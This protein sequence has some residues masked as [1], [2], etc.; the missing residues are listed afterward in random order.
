MI[1]NEHVNN[2][3]NA[4]AQ[5]ERELEKLREELI[6]KEVR[7][8]SNYNGQPYGKTRKPLTGKVFKVKRV[9]HSTST[10]GTC[11]SIQIEGHLLHLNLDEVELVTENEK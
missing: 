7:I 4:Y 1:N 10:S 8:I 5:A 11:I 2:V 3:I 9:Y 6:G